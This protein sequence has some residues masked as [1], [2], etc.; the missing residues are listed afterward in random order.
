MPSK[1]VSRGRKKVE[2]VPQE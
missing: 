2:K 1:R